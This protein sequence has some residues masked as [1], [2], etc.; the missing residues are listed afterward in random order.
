MKEK[1]SESEK[2]TA[3]TK[4]KQKN[5]K[6]SEKKSRQITSECE[7]KTCPY[8]DWNVSLLL[9]VLQVLSDLKVC[10]ED[11]TGSSATSKYERDSAQL[12]PTPFLY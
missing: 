8:L 3:R 2:I 7:E 6:Q 9:S 1:E 12:I 4:K 5:E 10:S 11:E